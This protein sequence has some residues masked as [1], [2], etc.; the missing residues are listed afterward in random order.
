MSEL[1]E[2]EEPNFQEGG[3]FNATGPTSRAD[4]SS[5]QTDRT[6]RQNQI[7]LER[8]VFIDETWTLVSALSR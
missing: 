5:G 3:P 6:N 1:D 2:V 4:A 7:D 8:L